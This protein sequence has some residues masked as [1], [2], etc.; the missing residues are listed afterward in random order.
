MDGITTRTAAPKNILAAF[1]DRGME[2][3]I[4]IKLVV[5]EEKPVG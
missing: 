5:L 1:F 4:V 3:D 2:W